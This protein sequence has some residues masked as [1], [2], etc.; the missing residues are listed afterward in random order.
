MN[1]LGRCLEEGWGCVPDPA[2]AALWYQR[3][4]ETG[5]FR[6]QF[7][8]AAVLAQYGHADAARSWYQKAAAGGDDALRGAVLRLLHTPGRDDRLPGDPA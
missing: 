6:G 4:A 3:S 1:L 7:N 8:Y 2:A 5:Y